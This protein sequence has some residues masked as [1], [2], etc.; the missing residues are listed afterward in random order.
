MMESRADTNI[1]IFSITWRSFLCSAYSIA[2]F[3]LK[4]LIPANGKAK[5]C[6]ATIAALEFWPC[7][8]ANFPLS[9][10]DSVCS[11]R[12]IPAAAAWS[13]TGSVC[14]GGVRPL[15]NVLDNYRP[16]QSIYQSGQQ[17]QMARLGLPGRPV[18]IMLARDKLQVTSQARGQVLRV[19]RCELSAPH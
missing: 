14:N 3:W 4:R 5:I 2:S 10:Q 11:F 18:A 6:M 15:W 9:I 13:Q 19:I 1:P 12:T 8:E 7:L 17:Q 16:V